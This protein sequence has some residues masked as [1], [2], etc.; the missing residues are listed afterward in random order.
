MVVRLI[1]H[2]VG[3]GHVPVVKKGQ[4]KKSNTGQKQVKE[5]IQTRRLSNQKRKLVQQKRFLTLGWPR[6]T[7]RPSAIAQAFNGRQHDKGSIPSSQIGRR[8]NIGCRRDRSRSPDRALDRV[9]TGDIAYSA[10]RPAKP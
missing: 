9:I 3:H 1:R 8:Q 5:K 2:Q 6:P 7:A 4:K 10:E